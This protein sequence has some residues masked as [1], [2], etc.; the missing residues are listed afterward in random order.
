MGDSSENNTELTA[1]SMNNILWEV[2]KIV[3]IRVQHGK[4]TSKNEIVEL[5]F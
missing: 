3:D 2:Y 4:V 5:I 1:T